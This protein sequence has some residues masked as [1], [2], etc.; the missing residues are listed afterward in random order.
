M[1]DHRHGKTGGGLGGDADMHRAETGENA[2]IVVE[3]FL[4]VIV[5]VAFFAHLAVSAGVGV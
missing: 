4:L 2:G 3:G 5:A 1:F